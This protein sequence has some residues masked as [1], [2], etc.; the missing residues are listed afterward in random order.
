MNSVNSPNG[1]DCIRRIAYRPDYV[2]VIGL[3]LS[4]GILLSQIRCS[5]SAPSSAATT[6]T[7]VS[8]LLSLGAFTRAPH[9]FVSFL[10]ELRW[11]SDES[12]QS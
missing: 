9:L 5:R 12:K 6:A 7:N 10:T 3:S 2:L 11:V 4:A 8:T 1:R